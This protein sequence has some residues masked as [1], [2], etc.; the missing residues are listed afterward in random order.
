MATKSQL[1]AEIMQTRSLRSVPVADA[2]TRAQ[3]EKRQEK[4]RRQLERMPKAQLVALHAEYHHISDDTAALVEMVTEALN[5]RPAVI[6]VSRGVVRVEQPIAEM[7][8]A[9]ISGHD[10]TVRAL[11]AA[12]FTVETGGCTCYIA[13]L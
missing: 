9:R 10:N 1:A 2:W 3:Q 4:R 5:G 13:G 6:S 11:E 8:R 12:G 7:N